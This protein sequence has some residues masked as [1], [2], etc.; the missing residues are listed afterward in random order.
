[1]LWFRRSW[2]AGCG[3]L[4]GG[5]LC[6]LECAT[7]GPGADRAGGAAVA[8]GSTGDGSSV[9][10]GFGSGSGRAPQLCPPPEPAE[11]VAADTGGPTGESVLACLRRLGSATDDRIPEDQRYGITTFGGPGDEQPTDCPEAGDADSSWYYAAN[12]Q[13]FPCGQR[14]RL[15]DGDRRRCVVVAIADTGPNICVEEAAALPEWDVSPLV[16]RHLFR[17]R[18]VGWSQKLAVYGAPVS[19]E[20]ALG[21]C[22]HVDDGQMPQ[23]GFIGGACGA[24][25]ACEYAGGVCFAD[26]AGWPGG[27]C[28]ASCEASCPTKPGAHAL[29]ACVSLWNGPSQCV[30]R[31]DFT[32]YDQGCRDGYACGE[33]PAGDGSG[34]IPVCLPARCDEG[35]AAR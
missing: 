27:H 30:A 13:R 28:S 3:A 19:N 4:L 6:V 18:S 33:A 31:C 10:G 34:A 25:A 20:N 11:W 21:P 9:P 8:S 29:T 24:D 15:V 14:I 35:P 22:N 2:L 1:M 26:A 5:S 32:L 23:D 7:H 12:K 16:S 17:M